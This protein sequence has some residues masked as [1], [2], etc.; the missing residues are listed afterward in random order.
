MEKVH[1]ALA[2]GVLT[3][4]TSAGPAHAGT[5]PVPEPASLVLLGVGAA[6]VSAVAW[7]RRRK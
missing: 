2:L 1:I 4:L 6:G 7:W 3:V 5:A